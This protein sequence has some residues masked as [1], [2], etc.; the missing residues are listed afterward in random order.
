MINVETMRSKL[1]EGWKNEEEEEKAKTPENEAVKKRRQ[2]LLEKRTIKSKL[3][4]FEGDEKGLKLKKDLAKKLVKD[5][6]KLNSS[7]YFC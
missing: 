4:I 6:K 7:V 1:E 3:M 2:K 5:V